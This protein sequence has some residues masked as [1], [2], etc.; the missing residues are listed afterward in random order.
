MRNIKRVIFIAI[1]I[2]GVY[3]FIKEPSLFERQS[4]DISQ[5]DLLLEKK[6]KIQT[7]SKEKLDLGLDEWIGKKESDLIDN[8]GEPIRKDLSAYNYNSYI[9][10]DSN[11]HYLVFGL[12]GDKIVTVFGAGKSLD[13]GS[14][15]IGS[16]HE[17]IAQTIDFDRELSYRKGSS[18]YR[19]ELKEEDLHT[20]PIGTLD[21]NT[22]IQF[23]FDHID[24]QLVAIRIVDGDTLLM[25]GGFDIE[26]RGK[27]PEKAALSKEDESL[28][29]RG[30][31]E[32]I[33]E[34]TNV[35]RSFYGKSLLDSSEEVQSVAYSHSKDMVEKDY[36][37]H[38]SK[39]GKNLVD[40][41]LEKNVSYQLAGENIASNYIDALAAVVGWLN[42]E[43]H[44]ESLL[45]DEFTHIGVG[46]Y[47]NNFTQNFIRK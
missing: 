24:N 26:Y 27:L 43:G 40:R 23:Y 4:S 3:F 29:E 13:L 5:K 2:L 22:F 32:Q 31:E 9:Y 17:Q 41:L 38:E 14:F 11:D 33:V 15:Q 30:Q 36:F 39:S 47:K 21:Q 6:E 37:S 18:I 20:Q 28:V 25:Q 16:S 35:L 7:P 10:S 19:I 12:S 45:N 46:V 42:S 1:I 44:R 8:F 34:I